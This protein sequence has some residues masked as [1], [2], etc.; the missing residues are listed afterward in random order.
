LDLV[1]SGWDDANAGY[2]TIRLG[3]GDGSFG[4]AVSYASGSS[5][6][7]PVALGDLNGDGL[8]D[9][10]K[11]GS[12]P[13]VWLGNGDGSFGPRTTFGATGGGGH[14]R[15]IDL[16]DLNNDGILDLVGSGASNGFP[17]GPGLLAVRLG[18][19]NGT[20]GAATSYLGGS[21]VNEG[22]VLGDFNGD[23]IVDI[24]MAGYGQSGTDGALVI[25]LGV[26]DG[27]FG[28][29]SSYYHSDVLLWDLATGDINGD[30]VLDIVSTGYD[31][32]SFGRSIVRFG[33]TE[34]G[35][36]PLLDFSLMTLADARQALP[37]FKRKREQLATQR[38]EIGAF[39]SRIDVAVNVLEIA[40]ENFKAAESRIRDADIAE[41]VSNLV[42][43]RILEQA[44]TAIFAQANQ[45][46]ALALQLLGRT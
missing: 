33:E 25:R 38:A 15:S 46:P 12:Y 36:S 23:G 18:L 4:S 28:A 43:L 40:R 2:N 37:V 42:R 41:E 24:A 20:F 10:V 30:G 22:Q 7:D 19:G 34:S 16:E 31:D 13:A 5:F 21:D 14:F 17:N 35:V 39:Q 6:G 44:A 32:A 29:E 27:T 45:Q 26:G 11:G 3:R 8:L 1:T 9:M